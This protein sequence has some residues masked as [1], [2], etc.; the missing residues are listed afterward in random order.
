MKK[1]I[2]SGMLTLIIISL[3]SCSVVLCVVFYMQLSSSVQSEVR[4]RASMLSETVAGENYEYLVISD[5]R[6]TIVGS[7][8]TVLYDDEQNAYALPNHAEREE[9][10]EALITGIGES[11]RFSDTL[12]QE[13]YYYAIRLSDSSVLRLAKTMSSIWGMFG[14]AIPIVSLVVLVMLVIGYFLA[15]N[16]TKR[17]VNPINTVN[18]EEKLS[19]PYDELAPFIQ[20]IS[21]QRER[22]SQQI[23]DLQNRSGT[24]A[25]IM[26]SMS[27]GVILVDR[28]GTLLSINKSAADIFTIYGSVE[29]KN[30]LEILRDVELNE[31]MRSALSGVRGEMNLS[32]SDKSYRVYFSPVTNSGAIILFLDITEKSVSE[33]L[34]RE[35]SAN[36]SHELKTPLTTIYGNAEMLETGMVK[37]A[38]TTQFYGK[39]KDEAARLIALIED[40]IMLSQLDE[41]SSEITTENVDLVSI[42]NEIVHSLE[43]KAK[44]QDVDITIL[45]FGAL[46]A[47]R[48][49]M[50]ELFYNLIDNAIKYNKF[51]GTVTVEISKVKNG[52]KITVSDTGIGI[53]PE[54]QNRVFERFYR[55]DK[56]RSKKTGGTGLGLAIVKHIVMAYDGTIELQ[57]SVDKGTIITI[58]LDNMI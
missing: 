22:I 47:N 32:H 54:S 36:V 2:F 1:R 43:A 8:G 11:R 39:I 14:G 53:P 5:M 4:Q 13:T 56:S 58:S 18:L 44:S 31:T 38:D 46:S 27:E 37:E 41:N 55:V 45:G 50:A 16:L 21:Q 49:Q 57:S 24:I 19:A 15:G 34:R 52:V 48:S 17:I 7:D 23:S 3:L 51:G 12:G 28:Q 9:I 6:L 10:S 20:T 33:K 26:D 30:I 29:G 40:I 25:A 42:A 35:F